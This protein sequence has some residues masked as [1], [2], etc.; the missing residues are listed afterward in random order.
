MP[1]SAWSVITHVRKAGRDAGPDKW[2]MKA[3]SDAIAAA[4]GAG[5]PLT[6]MKE[7]WTA[8]NDQQLS[9]LPLVQGQ[10]RAYTDEI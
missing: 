8:V 3:L 2:K 6:A 1:W 5:G 7:E 9:L 4:K 10:V